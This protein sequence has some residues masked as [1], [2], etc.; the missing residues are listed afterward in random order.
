MVTYSSRLVHNLQPG[1][2]SAKATFAVQ[3][4]LLAFEQDRLAVKRDVLALDLQEVI[5][6]KLAHIAYASEIETSILSSRTVIELYIMMN[7]SS[8]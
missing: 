7:E 2:V 3:R 8:A 1:K 6:L 4:R 5:C